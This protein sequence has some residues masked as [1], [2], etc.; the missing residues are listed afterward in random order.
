MSEQVLSIDQRDPGPLPS[1]T[2]EAPVTDEP[3]D[4]DPHHGGLARTIG[5]VLSAV[6]ATLVAFVAWAFVAS[7]IPYDQGQRALTERFADDLAAQA[8]PT[9]GRIAVGAPL[10]RLDIPG[11]GLRATVVEGTGPTQLEDAPGHLRGTPLPGQR[12]NVVLAGRRATHGGPFE[13]LPGLSAGEEILLTT[14]QGTARYEVVAHEQLDR[15]RPDLVETRAGSDDRLT[16]LTADDRFF[17]GGL[18]VVSARL[19]SDA[20]PAPPVA[21]VALDADE[22]GLEGDTGAVPALLA[23]VAV[24]AVVLAATLALHRH[25]ARTT[26]WVL[27][28]PVVLVVALELFDVF[29][30]LLPPLQ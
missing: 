3:G 11:L 13:A 24:L 29:D 30:R 27:S 5:W 21:A 6:G 28:S 2:P 18:H 19:R 25:A 9:G 12:G 22:L 1:P 23:W 8:A 10:A 4:P 14:A 7:V 15:V 20:W 17:P 26:A 16:L